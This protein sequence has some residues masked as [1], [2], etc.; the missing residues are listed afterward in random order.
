MSW[1]RLKLGELPPSRIIEKLSKAKQQTVCVERNFCR[2]TTS[3]AVS[4]CVVN[5]FV[6]LKSQKMWKEHPVG[7]V[8]L[9]QLRGDLD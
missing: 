9:K 4:N 5:K 2:E 7:I 8:T 6:C 1:V 3:E